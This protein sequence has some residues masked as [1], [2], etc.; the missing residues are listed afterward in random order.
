M[1]TTLL[2]PLQTFPSFERETNGLAACAAAAGISAAS[3]CEV[4]STL[5][6]RLHQRDNQLGCLANHPANAKQRV[7]SFDSFLSFSLGDCIFADPSQ[8]FI[9][10]GNRGDLLLLAPDYCRA[11]VTTIEQSA[12]FS[13]NGMATILKFWRKRNRLIE[14]SS[15]KSSPRPRQDPHLMAV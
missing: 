15:L 14:M 9:R 10:K 3:S 5:S 12:H 2:Y 7:C 4:P 13:W 1:L 11:Q 6:R 8:L